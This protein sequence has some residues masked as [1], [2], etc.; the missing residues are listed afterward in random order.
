MGKFDSP[1]YNSPALHSHMFG[2]KQKHML[3]IFCY[4]WRRSRANGFRP[5]FRLPL[6]FRLGFGATGE[7]WIRIPSDVRRGQIIL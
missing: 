1:P 6:N 7:P 2:V 5:P 3:I 4:V